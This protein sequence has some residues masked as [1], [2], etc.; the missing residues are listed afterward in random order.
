MALFSSV[1]DTGISFCSNQHLFKKLL[2]C[3]K[4][5]DLF[6]EMI[7][8]LH[9]FLPCNDHS[10][11]RNTP[12]IKLHDISPKESMWYVVKSRIKQIQ[13]YLFKLFNKY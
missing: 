4:L 5:L 2:I 3:S 11:L 13:F 10:W 8:S 12:S 1:N 9:P 6:V 7:T